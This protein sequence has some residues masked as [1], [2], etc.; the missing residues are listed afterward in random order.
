M[1]LLSYL[2]RCSHTQYHHVLWMRVIAKDATTTTTTTTTTIITITTSPTHGP[3]SHVPRP[4]ARNEVLA[5]APATLSRDLS[6]LSVKPRLLL[7]TSA[8]GHLPISPM[9]LHTTSGLQLDKRPKP[10]HQTL[11]KGRVG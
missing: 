4:T 5:F 3:M 10:F 6:S 1:T 11:S 8:S 7:P 2:G 9:S